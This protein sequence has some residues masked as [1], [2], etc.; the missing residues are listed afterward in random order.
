MKSY[1][2][3]GTKLLIQLTLFVVFLVNFGI[4]SLEKYRREETIIVHSEEVTQGF[5]A[6]V[7]TISARQGSQE[8]FF[9]SVS[10]FFSLYPNFSPR[11]LVGDQLKEN[12]P[13]ATLTSSNTVKTLR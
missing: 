3:P 4:P 7:V 11:E 1:L 9:L 8:T 6:P 12:T 5:E 13:G 2:I 10:Y